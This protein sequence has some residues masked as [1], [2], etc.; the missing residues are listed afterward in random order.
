MSE[1]CKQCDQPFWNEDGSERCWACAEK[2][3]K[4]DRTVSEISDV[5]DTMIREAI[6]DGSKDVAR[7]FVQAKIHLLAGFEL[8]KIERE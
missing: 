6:K 1:A 4:L 7:E 3:R 2:A 8:L 5:F